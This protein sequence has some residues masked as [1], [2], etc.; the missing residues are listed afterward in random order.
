[1]VRCN[2]KI[3]VFNAHSIASIES[4][5]TPENNKFIVIGDIE[6]VKISKTPCRRCF[7]I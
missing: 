5:T 3:S 6:G 2:G 4:E 1:M 7:K